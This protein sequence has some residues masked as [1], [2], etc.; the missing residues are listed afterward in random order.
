M[1]ITQKITFFAA[2][3]FLA[4]AYTINLIEI[5]ESAK[6]NDII[7]NSETSYYY[8]IK[9]VVII[10]IRKTG[11]EVSG[12]FI[13]FA[14]KKAIALPNDQKQAIFTAL[15]ERYKQRTQK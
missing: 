2:L 14:N 13:D 7:E 4:P 3:F 12:R 10:T 8:E 15:A 5:A 9:G 11:S 1:N 6:P